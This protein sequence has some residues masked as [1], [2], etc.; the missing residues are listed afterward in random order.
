MSELNK[1]VEAI[2]EC[3]ND[4]TAGADYS[5]RAMVVLLV[6]EI[7]KCTI[8]LDMLDVLRPKKNLIHCRDC[9]HYD[10]HHGLCLRPVLIIGGIG[11]GETRWT[12]ESGEL[13]ATSASPDGYC[14]WAE[15]RAD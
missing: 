9:R 4:E 1:K 3:I 13:A 15:R 14:A 10:E 12:D 5:E 8:E 7:L 6:S 2:I 11:E